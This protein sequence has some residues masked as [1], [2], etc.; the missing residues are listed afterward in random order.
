M[1]GCRA[2]VRP[3]HTR[4]PPVESSPVLDSPSYAFT[5]LEELKTQ[6]NAAQY[7]AEAKGAKARRGNTSGSFLMIG[8]MSK[9]A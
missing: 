8:A 9:I 2:R 7:R 6:N 5:I 3:F 1:M 4:I